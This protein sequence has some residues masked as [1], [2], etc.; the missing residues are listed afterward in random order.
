MKS[1][2]SGTNSRGRNMK[3]WA[4]KMTTM[5]RHSSNSSLSFRLVNYFIRCRVHIN[6]FKTNC[7]TTCIAND[8]VARNSVAAI[9]TSPTTTSLRAASTSSGTFPITRLSV[10]SFLF[11]FLLFFNQCSLFV[12][13]APITHSGTNS[14]ARPEVVPTLTSQMTATPMTRLDL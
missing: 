6:T 4:S 5:P 10:S 3:Q 2:G 9:A 12:H 7:I 11:I 8:A 14:T 13:P 1:R